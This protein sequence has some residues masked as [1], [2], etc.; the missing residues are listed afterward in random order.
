MNRTFY[1][2]LFYLAL[3]FILLRLWWRGQKAP[4]YKE[5][6]QERLGIIDKVAFGEKPLWIHAVSVGETLAIVPL[7]KLI[8]QR[9]PNL[10]IVMTTM[11]PTGAERVQANFADSVTHFY[12]PYDLPLSLSRFLTA[13]DPCGCVVVETELWPNM[14]HACH[15][16]RIPVLIA[17]ARLSA[18][19]ARGYARF[20]GLARS[21]LQQINRIAVQNSTDGQRFIDLGLPPSA[22]SVTG[23]IK[24]DISQPEG[25]ARLAAAL[26][27]MWGAQRPV[28]IGASTHE[29]EEAALLATFAALKQRFPDLLLL[30]VPRHP[31]R[32]QSVASLIKAQGLNMARRSNGDQPDSTT[33]V[34][35]GDTMGELMKLLAAADIAFVGGSLIERGG[36]NPLEPAVLGK[37]VIMGPHVFNFQ[38]ICDA[39]ADAGGLNIIESQKALTDAVATLLADPQLAAEQGKRGALFVQQNQGALERLYTLTEQVCLKPC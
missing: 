33:E 8:Q 14:I 35:L 5:R 28:L 32:F 11:T 26:R 2:L 15:A 23:S 4:A 37:P 12:C 1:S 38:Q 21:M 31:E 30:L 36:H 29:A 13:V 22:L 24:F 6:W 27:Q 10:P 7:V 16:R 19:S 17:N 18:R 25:S 20:A 3:P 9:H 34:Y 39:L